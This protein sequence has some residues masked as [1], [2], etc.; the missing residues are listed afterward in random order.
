MNYLFSSESVSEG[1]PDKVADQ[2]S[3]AL[4]DQ[5][6]AY[7][8]RAHCAI[9]SFVTTGQVVIM[10][11]VRSNVY[12]DL[13]TIARKTINQIGYNKSDYQFDGNSCGV[14]TAI[15]EQS[16]DINRGVSR[17]DEEEQGA[18]DQGMMFGYATNETEN[19]MPVTLD[20]AQLIM[21]V[22]ADIRK[23]G[24]QMTYLRPDSK[25]QVT[26]EYSE[27]G[28]PQ[29]ID[30]IVVSTQHDEFDSDDERMLAKIKDDVLNILMPRVKAEI[31]SEKVLA[32]FGDD[33]KYFVNP[34]GKFVI[35][36]PHG[37]TGLTGRK[38]IVDTYG[39]KGAHGGGAFSGKDPSKVDRSAAYAARYIAKNMVAAGV[40]DEM[41]VQVSYAIGV[42]KP[43]NIYVNTYGRS[44]VQM[45]D[46][47]IA[48]KI[49]KLFDLRPKAIERTLKLRQPIYRE[50]AAYG[51][52]GRK[53]EVVEKTFT[54]RYH[55]TKVMKVE[56]FTWEKLD[57]VD[58]IRKE[59]G[60]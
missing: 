5:F 3:D 1:H 27:E 39:G 15:H 10:G 36:G 6:L 54:S 32:L 2:I 25:S 14:L 41:L 16:D 23:E 58:D 13:Q 49:E 47:E 19:Y 7:D 11:E 56:L 18:G 26:V 8:D 33:I 53:C 31:H 28:I 24:K 30:T 37:D 44:R 12:I 52:M 45:S 51:H 20:I 43:V 38:I 46:G 42:A 29:R 35:G 9:E 59:F 57:R 34:T 4:V 40:A 21:R 48:Q 55:E 50:T 17:A 60:I 22:L